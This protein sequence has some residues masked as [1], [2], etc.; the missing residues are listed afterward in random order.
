MPTGFGARSDE[1]VDPCFCLFDC[2]LLG[3]N[4]RGGCHS[5]GSAHF[6]HVTGWYAQG[7]DDEF[8]RVCKS[9]VNDGGSPARG[10]EPTGST[11]AID[12]DV[13]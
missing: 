7:V 6:D 12:V 10:E 3:A 1:Y 11:K 9:D 5:A 2:M 4:Q 8:D 13:S